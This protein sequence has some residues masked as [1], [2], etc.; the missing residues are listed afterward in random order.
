MTPPRT[1]Q[2]RCA[3]GSF[4]TVSGPAGDT[5]VD[6]AAALFDT[7]HDAC[8]AGDNLMILRLTQQGDIPVPLFDL[9]VTA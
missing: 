8:R 3:C 9:D 1:I 7:A 2:R 6:Q 5:L 4:L